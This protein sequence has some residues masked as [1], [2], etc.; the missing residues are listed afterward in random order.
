MPLKHA[1]RRLAKFPLFTS[2]AVLTL[3]IGIGANCAIFAVVY[4]VLLKP[5]PY[6]DSG[7]LVSVDHSAPG[8]NIERAGAAPFLYFTYREQAKSFE[9]IGLYQ[10]DTESVTG[11]A[12][13][14]EIPA[15]AVSQGVLPALGVRPAVGRLFTEA[16]DAP[17]SPETTILTYAYWQ[18]RFAGDPS[19]V[20]RR[21]MFDGRPREIIGILPATFRFLDRNPSAL[22]PLQLDRNKTF[23]GQ[24]SY[25]AIA[26]LAPGATID[27]A[28]A[29]MARL[30]PISIKT[31]PAFPGYSPK[32]FTDARLAPALRPLKDAIVG[33]VGRVLWVL[34]G[35]IG[36]VLLIACANVAN[37]LL[38]RTDGR[39]Q[40]LA[41]RAALGA[42]WTRIA[43]ELMTE[44]VILGICGG[45]IGLGLAY[46]GVRLLA[47]VA[48]ANLPR[49]TDI[50]ISGPVLVFSLVLSI[51][52]G[53][54]FGGVLVA[55][56]A[57]PRVATELRAGGRTMS[58]GRDR[59]RARNMLVIAQIALAMVLLVGSGLMVR[60][61]QALRHV[62]PGFTHPEDVLT[63]RITIPAAAVKDAA[64]V[65]RVQQTILDKIAAI[66]GVTSVGLTNAVPMEGEHWSDPIYADDKQYADGKMPALR[67]FKQVSPGLLPTLGTPLVAGRDF[68]WDDVYQLRP[69][70]LVSENLARE[71]WGSPTAAIG[72]SVRESMKT[73]WRQ[74]IGVVADVRDDGVD[75]KAPT[76]AYFPTFMHGFEGDDVSI[77]RGPAFVI[78]S[79]RA[80]SNSLLK[81]VSQAV[82]S[83][84]PSLPLA[85]VRTLQ[86]IYDKS[87]ARTSFS[88]IMLS[89][90]GLMAVM[91]GVAG[92][93]GV[94][95]YA[96]SQRRREIGIRVALGARPQQVTGLF[97]AQGLRLAAIGATL[98]LAGAAALMRLM[99]TLLF[100]VSAVDPLTYAGVAIG[101]VAVALLACYVPAVR[102]AAVSPL[103]ALH[104]E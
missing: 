26:R 37:L 64:A 5:L 2:V 20:G 71:L 61:F 42:G 98:G 11:L 47:A 55:K 92:M 63:M 18:A 13:P 44:S 99:A 85:N 40:E 70:A 35:T 12:E 33:D 79:S 66:P 96:V 62:Q 102:A 39:Q 16:D 69:V 10:G 82:W 87:L 53:V 104:A 75:Q 6:P 43:R 3:A 4:G 57:R 7:R 78:R 52:A 49:V 23:L 41:V 21:V 83:V 48:P 50:G 74:I 46:G 88:L 8:V 72:R 77:R 90:A 54:L 60:T 15:V 81:D 93:Y 38:V 45:V 95:S 86:E 27:S 100:G 14:E 73:P 58:A 59:Q 30:I 25:E 94:I 97:V 56:Y 84:N 67:R 34:M 1:L 91:L 29:D 51:I 65:M 89:I 36:I 31:F 80:R 68:S 101:L 32:M 9:A 24:F 76:S 19:A 103:E 22:V 17:G 28:T